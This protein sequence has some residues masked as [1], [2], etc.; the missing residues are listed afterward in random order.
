VA[1]VF[2]AIA[3]LA[4]LGT[5]GPIIGAVLFGVIATGSSLVGVRIL[6]SVWANIT[7]NPPEP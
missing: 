6:R 2:G 7:Q 5:G 4:A 3:L 1:Y